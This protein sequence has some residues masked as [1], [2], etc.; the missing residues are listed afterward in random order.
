VTTFIRFARRS[1]CWAV[2]ALALIA[3]CVQQEVIAPATERHSAAAHEEGRRIY[4]F[5]CYYCHGYSGDAKTLAASFVDPK[6]RDFQAATPESLPRAAMLKAVRDGRPGTAMA[7]FAGTLNE[8]EIERV[9]DFVSAEFIVGKRPNTR[10]HTAEN[11]WPDHERYAVA[12]PFATGAIAVDTPWESLDSEQA[13]GKHLYL[14]A[15]VSCHDRGRVTQMGEPWALRGVSFPLGN[16][17]DERYPSECLGCHERA[18]LAAVPVRVMAEHLPHASDAG[19]PY[20][21]HERVPQIADLTRVEKT[22]AKLFLDNC[23]HCHAADGSGRNWRGSFLDPHPPDFTRTEVAA[24]LTRQRVAAA[25]RDGIAG[26]SMPAWRGVLST[27]QMDSISAYVVRAWG[28]A[29]LHRV[30]HNDAR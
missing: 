10:Y 27:A 6:P 20:E 16:Y 24:T 23:A 11:G 17:D 18:A 29:G 4:N 22:G 3:G 30:A 28:T 25:M 13:R 12:F 19:D 8:R 7:A 5:R 21:L 15:C 9:V 1:R 26:T 2:A 14:S